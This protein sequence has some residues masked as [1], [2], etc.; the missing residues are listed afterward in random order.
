MNNLKA[1]DGLAIYLQR[2]KIEECF[3]DLKNLLGLEKL[4]NKRRDQMEKMVALL[5]IAYVI[6]LWLGEILRTVLLPENTYK[7]KLYS[8]LFVFLKLR[9]PPNFSQCS[10]QALASFSSLIFNVRTFV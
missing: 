5:M 8:G 3:R 2:I 9:P 1:E 6:G 4:M 7:H 10:L